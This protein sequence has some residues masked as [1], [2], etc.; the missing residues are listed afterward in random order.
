SPWIASV[1]RRHPGLLGTTSYWSVSPAAREPERT[2]GGLRVGFE[3]DSE[4]F[5]PI[6]RWALG[7][8]FAV[9][10]DVARIR[11]VD[12]WPRPTL[13]ALPRPRL[14]VESELPHA[15]DGGARA[16]SRCV[17]RAP[18]A[19]ARSRNPPRARSRRA[20]H[21]RG[22]VAVA[23]RRIVLDRRERRDVRPRPARV[24]S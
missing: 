23:P 3:D 22:S 11:D 4:Y 24:F 17:R 20:A 13:D 21:R 8:M 9:P 6:T 1:H 15:L 19:R 14:G 7:R 12:V 2:E 16:R 10:G 18:S 5:G